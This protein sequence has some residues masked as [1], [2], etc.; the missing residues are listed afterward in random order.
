MTVKDQPLTDKTTDLERQLAEKTAELEKKN[1]ELQIESSLEKVRA[2]ALSMK[3]PSDM[4]EICKT[5]SAQLESL[6]VKEIRNV[7]TAIFHEDRGTY[8]NY[9]SYAKHNKTVFT[10]TNY[11]DHPEATAFAEQM[12][13]GVGEVYIHSLSKKELK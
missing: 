3:Q 8:F 13:K 11:K 6:G 1:R 4:L 2:I 7:Q 10:E 5:I 9:E 12:L